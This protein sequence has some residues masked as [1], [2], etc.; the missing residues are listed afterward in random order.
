M[1]MQHGAILDQLEKEKVLSE[2]IRAKIDGAIKECS[3]LFSS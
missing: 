1:Q 3:S 2:D